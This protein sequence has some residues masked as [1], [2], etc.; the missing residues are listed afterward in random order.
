MS[1][2]TRKIDDSPSRCQALKAK[3]FKLRAL[4]G[5]WDAGASFFASEEVFIAR[6]VIY[7]HA[8]MEARLQGLR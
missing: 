5:A 3:K 4:S 6:A 1:F 8:C 7:G 2:H